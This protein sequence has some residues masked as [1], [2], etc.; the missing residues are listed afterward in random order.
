AMK[1]FNEGDAILTMDPRL[2]RSA[3]TSLAI[4]KIFE[5]AYQCLAPTRQNRPSMKR[6][7]EILW[8]IRKDLKELSAF[9]SHS[10]SSQSQ[11]SSSIRD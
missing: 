11:T 7:A 1:K 5:L 9:D 3:A 2:H 6:C 8:G 4:E 10:F